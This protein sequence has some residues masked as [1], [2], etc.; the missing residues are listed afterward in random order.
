[1][2]LSVNSYSAYAFEVLHVALLYLVRKES[3]VKKKNSME[4]DITDCIIVNLHEDV[5]A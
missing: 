5:M 3:K 2:Y 4:K 1:M